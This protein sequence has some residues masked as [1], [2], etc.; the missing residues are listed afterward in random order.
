MPFA[1]KDPATEVSA[2]MSALT[3]NE[4]LTVEGDESKE[5]DR[6]PSDCI[7]CYVWKS[8]A[9]ENLRAVLFDSLIVISLF[10]TN[11]KGK[12]IRLNN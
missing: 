11:P 7:E 3:D 12:T 9:E 4:N 1:G 8:D 10:R 5:Q 2:G 6:K